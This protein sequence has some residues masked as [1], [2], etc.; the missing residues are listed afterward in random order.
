MGCAVH[1]L[2]PENF[3]DRV[4]HQQDVAL[5]LCILRAAR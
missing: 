1:N 2:V 4:Y 5:C 3:K